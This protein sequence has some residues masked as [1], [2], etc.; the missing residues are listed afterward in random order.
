MNLW[1]TIF[2]VFFSNGVHVC[3]KLHPEHRQHKQMRVYFHNTEKHMGNRN[4]SY[5]VC[6][7]NV[8]KMDVRLLMEE[9][10]RRLCRISSINT[11]MWY[12]LICASILHHWSETYLFPARSADW[13]TNS[14][15]LLL[16]P[17]SLKFEQSLRSIFRGIFPRFTTLSLGSRLKSCLFLLGARGGHCPKGPSL[18]EQNFR[19]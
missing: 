6:H 16:P 18:P 5:P 1:K 17:S 19:V 7:R 15:F 13:K 4:P 8:W 3:C 2:Q 10:L 12:L 11:I 9:I 14:C